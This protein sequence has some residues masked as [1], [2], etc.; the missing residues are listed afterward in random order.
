[1]GQ[2]PICGKTEFVKIEGHQAIAKME[3]ID[4]HSFF[5]EKHFIPVRVEY[6]KNCGHA[7]FFV[8]PELAAKLQ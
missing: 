6:C 5:D 1:M 4:N 8:E 3:I 2:C 7:D